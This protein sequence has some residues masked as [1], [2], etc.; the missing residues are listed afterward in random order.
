VNFS[1]NRKFALKIARLRNRR[2]WLEY[3]RSTHFENSLN[4]KNKIGCHRKNREYGYFLVLLLSLLFSSTVLARP[5]LLKPEE[6]SKLVELRDAIEH[7]STDSSDAQRKFEAK[8]IELAKLKK[9]LVAADREVAITKEKRQKLEDADSQDPGS[10][11]QDRLMLVRSENDAAYDK[12]RKVAAQISKVTSAQNEL[13]QTYLQKSSEEELLLKDY[14]A[15][16]GGLVERVLASRKNEFQKPQAVEATGIVSCND[17]PVKE[18]KEKSLREAERQAIERG[19]VIV[20]DSITEIS[21]S[22]MTKDQIR[23]ATRGRISSREILEAKF[24]NNDTAFQTHIHAQVTPGLGP[25]LLTEMRHAAR[26][27]IEAEIGG[28]VSASTNLPD[29]E[30]MVAP[31]SRLSPATSKRAE[32]SIRE[33]DD[34][35]PAEEIRRP[36]KRDP[37]QVTPAPSQQRASVPI[38]RFRWVFK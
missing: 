32:A 35:K 6:L 1:T 5:N 14:E 36:T 7:F 21:N 33:M 31:V 20:V 37:P 10:I 9:D 34:D 23:S 4:N 2:R 24:V 3:L 26:L 8:K 16:I 25:E 29:K 18:C 15:R 12:K 11:N 27:D 17:M 38:P 30:N 13:E 22:T 28:G 19:S